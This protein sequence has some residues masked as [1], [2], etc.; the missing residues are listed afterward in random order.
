V[1]EQEDE[2]ASDEDPHTNESGVKVEVNMTNGAQSSPPPNVET[3]NDQESA[4]KDSHGDYAMGDTLEPLDKG[5]DKVSIAD[6]MSSGDMSPP[7]TPAPTKAKKTAT[8]KAKLAAKTP[9]TPKTPTGEAA[10]TSPGDATET[11]VAIS[12]SAKKR[13]RK[14]KAQKA[15]DAAAAGE[16]GA[17]GNDEEE[18]GE[19][20]A[21]KARMTAVK[22]VKKGSGAKD[23]E[24]TGAVEDEHVEEPPVKKSR[25][26]PVKK[27]KN[28]AGAENRDGDK[29]DTN[30]GEDRQ[31]DTPMKKPRKT[32]V[33]KGKKEEAAPASE[34]STAGDAG[35]QKKK[36]SPQPG[37]AKA[38]KAATVVLPAEPDAAG[39]KEAA[40]KVIE[41]AELA[42]EVLGGKKIVTKTARCVQLLF[43]HRLDLTDGR[44]ST[45]DATVPPPGWGTPVNGYSASSS[46]DEATNKLAAGASTTNDTADGDT[47][48]L[49]SELLESI[50]RE[51]D[52]AIDTI[53][54]VTA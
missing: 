52:E 17:V 27:A 30:N 25:K 19:K 1:E 11:P 33:K 42:N 54:I 2:A 4:P 44:N 23:G 15:A 21:K 29:A 7:T 40:A 9:K 43:Y 22:K 38:K 50:E 39:E 20:S 32:P 34:S 6:E 35:K 45:T 46:K 47:V 18:D 49:A 26:T 12:P 37:A 16:N 5:K 51:D 41:A 28:D 36:A 48:V 8:P 10:N 13:G 24:A 31:A 53:T 3:N 14:T